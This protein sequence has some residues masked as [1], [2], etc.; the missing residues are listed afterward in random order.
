M[1]TLTSGSVGQSQADRLLQLLNSLI[2]SSLIYNLFNHVKGVD[3]ALKQSIPCCIM[4]MIIWA[5]NLLHGGKTVEH[6]TATG[7]ELNNITIMDARKHKPGSF[8]ETGFTL[9]TLDKV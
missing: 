3:F 5:G 4:K 7:A 2:F 9:I 1:Y 8:K 6:V